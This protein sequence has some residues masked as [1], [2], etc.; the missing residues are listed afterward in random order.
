MTVWCFDGMI[1]LWPQTAEYFSGAWLFPDWHYGAFRLIPLVFAAASK[2]LH[3]MVSD[4]RSSARFRAGRPA[5]SR[6]GRRI[7]QCL[8]NQTV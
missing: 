6:A 1:K 3:S 7:D 5:I 8:A 2:P 4:P